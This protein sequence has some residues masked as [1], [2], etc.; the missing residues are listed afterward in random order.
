MANAWEKIL[1]SISKEKLEELKKKA[2]QGDLGDM[3]K[4]V[5]KEK[6]E[7]L[8]SQMGWSDMVKSSDISKAL[9]AIKQNPELLQQLK[10]KL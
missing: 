2:E 5:D 6:A 3:L 8:L 10:K 1:N 4:S 7:K 9:D